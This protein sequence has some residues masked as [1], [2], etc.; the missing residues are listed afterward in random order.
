MSK[1]GG[2]YRAGQVIGI[3]VGVIAGH[4]LINMIFGPRNPRPN[5]YNQQYNQQYNAPIANQNYNQPVGVYE[6]ALSMTMHQNRAQS[7]Q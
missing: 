3:I 2:W 7:I 5:D 1:K 4:T 6:Q